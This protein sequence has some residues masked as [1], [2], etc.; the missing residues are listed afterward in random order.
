M[1]KKLFNVAV[2]VVDLIWADDEEQA[3]AIFEA[4]LPVD[5]LPDGKSAFVSEPIPEMGWSGE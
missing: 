3:I 1:G 5:V 2:R 4:R